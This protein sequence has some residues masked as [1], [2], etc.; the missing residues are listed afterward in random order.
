MDASREGEPSPDATPSM[1]SHTTFFRYKQPHPLN[2]I[3]EPKRIAVIGAT[4]RDGSVGR[5]LLWNLTSNSFGGT[6]FPINSK[7]E[8]ILGI[9]AYPNLATLPEQVN[10]A[11]IATPPPSVPG[12]MADCVAAGVKGVI[13]ISD[14]FKESGAAGAKME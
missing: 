10:L 13:I 11:V 9:K 4:E 2:A 6:V 3:F 14:G 1:V 5:T 8:S 7:H 12:I